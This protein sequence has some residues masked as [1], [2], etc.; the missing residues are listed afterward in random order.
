MLSYARVGFKDLLQILDDY[1]T[2]IDLAND[3]FSQEI[4]ADDASEPVIRVMKK[5]VACPEDSILSRSISSQLIEGGQHQGS[6]SGFKVSKDS[7][8]VRHDE[9][10]REEFCSAS[11]ASSSNSTA[12]LKATL[13]KAAGNSIGG[14]V[15]SHVQKVRGNDERLGH[16]FN[17]TK[18]SNE[19]S[20]SENGVIKEKKEELM[21]SS[22][23]NN[24][25]SSSVES[26]VET[27][28]KSVVELKNTFKNPKPPSMEEFSH[29]VDVPSAETDCNEV[30]TTIISTIDNKSRQVNL[31]KS[32]GGIAIEIDNKL[33]DKLSIKNNL[34]ACVPERNGLDD[35]SGSSDE[36]KTIKSC[37]LPKVSEVADQKQDVAD[38]KHSD[39]SKVVCQQVSEI[40][41]E[42]IWSATLKHVDSRLVF[43]VVPFDLQS[44]YAH[45]ISEHMKRSTAPVHNV[46]PGKLVVTSYN[47]SKVRCRVL[48]VDGETVSLIDID[49]GRQ[50]S[51]NIGSLT[52]SSDILSSIPPLAIPVKLYGI[53]KNQN[54]DSGKLIDTLNECFQ[55]SQYRCKVSVM[56]TDSKQFP[57]I[58]HIRYNMDIENDGN[59]ALDLVRLGVCDI[60]TNSSKWNS[61]VLNHG[62][63]WMSHLVPNLQPLLSLPNPIPV[64][65][66]S[67]FAATAHGIP[68]LLIN[69]KEVDP[70]ID[71]SEANRIGAHFYPLS[72]LMLNPSDDDGINENIE[73]YSPMVNA[74]DESFQQRIEALAAAAKN[75]EKIV[76]PKMGENVLVLYEYTDGG[77]EWCRGV[78]ESEHSVDVFTVILTDYGQRI[79]VNIDK[80]SRLDHAEKLMPAQLFNARFT[81]PTSNEEL[82][83]IRSDVADD[84]VLMR[85]ENISECPLNT[86]EIFVSI[87]KCTKNAFD[88]LTRIC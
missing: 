64:A 80:I 57:C 59:M 82:L 49:N 17:I 69:G 86:E 52:I 14:G 6:Y 12:I 5:L 3:L 2:V 88:E 25:F 13:S 16:K 65:V 41:L 18:K 67:W 26:I 45:E 79:F 30:E 40:P 47:S 58:G 33:K 29:F 53:S 43:W 20:N 44:R 1:S 32:F 37:D 28:M 54:I 75:G 87:W 51:S 74:L 4:N 11:L 9:K 23:N 19:V 84:F 56:G 8:L 77:G 42:K 46:E 34:P 60:I 50:F 66:G 61:E 85:V 10:N 73:F 35:K 72:S 71:S 15:H 27:T 63:E 38:N 83:S 22:T 31:T 70:T 21:I 39:T 24:S 36:F 7:R 55:N 76:N 81:M 68:Y 62:L 78:I 48:K